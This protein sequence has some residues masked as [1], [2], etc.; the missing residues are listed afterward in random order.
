MWSKDYWIAVFERFIATVAQAGAAT[1]VVTADTGG[2]VLEV[3]WLATGSIALLAGVLSILKSLAANAATKTGP[4]L[5]NAEVVE[6]SP[7]YVES[8]DGID[9]SVNGL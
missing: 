8:P 4:S 9:D 1:L 2:G 3:D 5:T 7:P 6:P